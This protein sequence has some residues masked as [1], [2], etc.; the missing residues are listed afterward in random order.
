[1]KR[2]HYLH[3]QGSWNA[4]SGAEADLALRFWSERADRYIHI[5][6]IGAVL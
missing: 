3:V 2:L 4:Y 6:T 5:A 1:M